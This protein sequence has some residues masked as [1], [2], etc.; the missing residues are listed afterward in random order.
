[1]GGVKKSVLER[2]STRYPVYCKV[3]RS[4]RQEAMVLVLE[5][6]FPIRVR[7]VGFVVASGDWR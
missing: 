4:D 7:N 3:S 6:S 1:M 2:A 5:F